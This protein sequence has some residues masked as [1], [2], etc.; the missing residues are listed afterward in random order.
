MTAA[1]QKASSSGGKGLTNGEE[2][3]I[4]MV[5]QQQKLQKL[6]PCGHFICAAC[7]VKLQQYSEEHR[8]PFCRQDFVVLRSPPSLVEMLCAKLQWKLP[9]AEGLQMLPLNIREELLRQLKN[10]R[11]L[12]GDTLLALIK[13]V[14]LDELRLC[15]ATNM[16][17]EH[18]ECA[19]PLLA[20][21]PRTLLLSNIPMLKDNGLQ[22]LLEVSAQT[23]QHLDVSLA[24]DDFYGSSLQAFA[25]RLPC[26]QRLVVSG[27]RGLTSDCLSDVAAGC[28][29][30]LKIL[31]VSACR[32]L[33]NE[34][35]NG[36]V[37]CKELRN[38]NLSGIWTL[39]T[40][41][42]LAVLESCKMLSVLNVTHC[43]KLDGPQLYK[44]VAT[45]CT[46]IR[47]FIT[48]A[49][50]GVDDEAV[51]SMAL[52][53]AGASL[54]SWSLA[55]SEITNDSLKVIRTQ[56][57][58]LTRLDISDCHDITEGALVDTVMEMRHLRVCQIK[59]CRRISSRLQLFVSQLL[60]GRALGLE[61]EDGRPN[62][63]SN[64]RG[65]R[66]PVI[67]HTASCSTSCSSDDCSTT[68]SGSSSSSSPV[69]S[70]SSTSRS[71][72]T[73][74]ASGSSA[75]KLDDPSRAAG[76]SSTT[77][78][79]TCSKRLVAR[80][81]EAAQSSKGGSGSAA[82]K[83][84]QPPSV[85]DDDKG[86]SS[87]AH[88]VEA[89]PQTE[90]NSTWGEH[91]S[92]PGSPVSPS[93]SMLDPGSP[94]ST[95]TFAW[96]A[97]A[98]VSGSRPQVETPAAQESEP[99]SPASTASS[100]ASPKRSAARAST[101]PRRPNNLASAGVLASSVSRSSGTT[102]PAGLVPSAQRS[103]TRELTQGRAALSRSGGSSSLLNAGASL[104]GQNPATPKAAPSRRTGS[105][106]GRP[107]R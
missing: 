72:P 47:E 61:D 71:S 10:H 93:E 88:P 44:G 1:L 102:S 34:C 45:H 32:R 54:E 58:V 36:V 42:L 104:G 51:L 70:A 4:C 12:Y 106:L 85:D 84:P 81:E 97:A 28:A 26:L 96:S 89:L 90:H 57:P 105:S 76:S 22:A 60:A 56:C 39:Q 98:A 30:T 23:L 65:S 77:V 25:S 8:C 3:P 100:S 78:E 99:S 83:T 2:C 52:S 24:A 75:S 101:L 6:V 92:K 94:C 48:G 35:L 68:A 41:P 5:P 17:N 64:S 46:E 15:D 66:A 103:Q 49:L 16:T 38:L 87:E 50:P 107:Q 62:K 80:F 73:S 7:A 21:P 91:P 67:S 53:T 37:K 95:S 82:Q 69:S 55:G 18:L 43:G 74:P 31:D 27:C 79:G 29:A 40:P 20:K 19:A 11:L 59:Y 13:D 33:T 86:T 9:K 14:T 63:T